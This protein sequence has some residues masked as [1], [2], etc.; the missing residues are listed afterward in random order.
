[1]AKEQRIGFEA[2][3]QNLFEI[4][5]KNTPSETDNDTLT[6]YA[7]E[8]MSC[9]SMDTGYSRNSKIQVGEVEFPYSLTYQPRDV[10]S[11]KE[12]LKVKSDHEIFW[13]EVEITLTDTEIALD[14][15]TGMNEAKALLLA[16]NIAIDTI[17]TIL[18]LSD[19]EEPEE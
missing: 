6:Q 1:M 19:E 9:I 10:K 17:Y 18:E 14:I 8:L 13:F 5:N 4:A 16:G 3:M 11:E 7:S 12:Q 15:D 2:A